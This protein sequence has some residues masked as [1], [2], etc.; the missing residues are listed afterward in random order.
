MATLEELERGLRGAH[1]AGNTEHAKVFA[2][3]IRDMQAS[4]N[5]GDEIGGAYTSGP[6]ED[7]AV[8]V[9][10]GMYD[11][12]RG[13]KDLW[14]RATDRG[15]SNDDALSRLN[16]RAEEEQALFDRNLGDS[17]SAFAGEMI[18]EIAATLPVG[19]A[20]GGLGR[21][22]MAA[23]KT[24]RLAAL[25]GAISEGITRRGD[26]GERLGAA[27]GGAAGGLLGDVTMK[28]LGKGVTKY[29]TKW[30]SEGIGRR[31]TDASTLADKRVAQAAEDGG[32]TLDRVDAMGEGYGERD[33]LRMASPEYA[34]FKQAQEDQIKSKASSFID[35]ELQGRVGSGDAVREQTANNLAD[36]LKS[37]KTDGEAKVNE[38]F[39]QWR[40]MP[41]GDER[42]PM[43][44]LEDRMNGILNDRSIF[45]EA[46]KDELDEPV[47]RVLGEY[48]M[49]AKQGDDAILDAAGNPAATGGYTAQMIEEVRQQLNDYY[50]R[51]K[52]K[53]AKRAL[54]KVKEGIDEH[55]SLQFQKVGDGAR[56]T[57]QAG[58]KAT[59]AFKEH[60]AVWGNRRFLGKLTELGM[61][62]EAFKTKPAIT[63]RKMLHSDNVS[64]LKRLKKEMNS[65]KDPRLKK[66]WQGM[67]DLPLLEAMEA[68]LKGNAKDLNVNAYEAAIKRI[69][70]EAREVLWGKSK[71]NQVERAVKAWK[72]HATAPSMKGAVNRSNTAGAMHNFAGAGV[73]LA[74]AGGAGQKILALVPLSA[75]ISKIM[76]QGQL[77]DDA[78]RLMAG[79]LPKE[80]EEQLV[81]KVKQEL[82]A[83]YGNPA[84]AQF[85][86]P[87]AYLA[88]QLIRESVNGDD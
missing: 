27:A 63:L 50:P 4:E 40:E 74:A 38:A 6:L 49:L 83:A 87:L 59:E 88:R 58:R 48:G 79:K 10:K 73:R 65:L 71:A 37:V 11:V 68:G 76:K 81:Q 28:G 66:A 47:R 5:P 42:I 64:D 56:D 84:V 2:N 8:G 25:E 80:A 60:D 85:D 61:D 52:S 72:L 1:A 36:A 51:M 39:R 46:V 34:T 7:F 14:L 15:G 3:A 30:D 67:A 55:V 16:S 31:A 33:A 70:P 54:E 21:G 41:G 18:G 35:P 13:A 53:R 78:A 17:K 20:V 62:G 69:S 23:G 26:A 82:I 12:G 24:A 45:S 86:E 57:L 29:R 9:G 19:G 22:A 77:A 75:G 43:P 44:G 32:F